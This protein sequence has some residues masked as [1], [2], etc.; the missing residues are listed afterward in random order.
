MRSYGIINLRVTSQEIIR[1]SH[2]DMRFQPHLPRVSE[3][4]HKKTMPDSKVYEAN[5]GPTWALLALDGPH[6][7]HEPCY[8]GYEYLIGFDLH[9]SSMDIVYA[10]MRSPVNRPMYPA[11]DTDR[12]SVWNVNK[13]VV[14][15]VWNN[16]WILIYAFKSHPESAGTSYML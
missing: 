16:T 4:E 9:L 10:C 15:D 8:Q 14:N 11:N 6:V 3:L 1:T 13:W 5:M 2:P 7:G 12:Y